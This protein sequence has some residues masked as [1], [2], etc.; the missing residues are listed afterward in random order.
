MII[1]CMSVYNEETQIATAINSLSWCDKVCVVD[2]SYK[3]FPE[4]GL[5]TDNTLTIAEDMGCEIALA[6]VGISQVEKRNLYLIGKRGDYY[7]VLDADEV[8][9]G[10]LKESELADTAYCVRHIGEHALPPT[11]RVF[12]HGVKYKHVHNQLYYRNVLLKESQC[13][14]LQT[15]Y[16]E[17]FHNKRSQERKNKAFKYFLW[18]IDHEAEKI[19][20]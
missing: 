17:H 15:V 7:V 10:K 1:G 3:G 11:I 9:H 4:Q 2:G 5:S 8:W 20:R 16:I 13:K 18:Q 12:R 6:P 19:S 14:V